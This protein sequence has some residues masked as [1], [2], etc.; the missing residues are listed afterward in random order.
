ML[1]TLMISDHS[2]PLDLG[3]RERDILGD[4]YYNTSYGM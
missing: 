1:I 4:Y 3:R 2:T